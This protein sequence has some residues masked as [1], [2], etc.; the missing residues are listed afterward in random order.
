VADLLSDVFK[1]LGRVAWLLLGGDRHGNLLERFGSSCFGA[2]G[3]K[4][5]ST[6]ARS[7]RWQKKLSMNFDEFGYGL[8]SAIHAP[9]LSDIS[10]LTGMAIAVLSR[11]FTITI[12][13]LKEIDS[14]VHDY[15]TIANASK[16]TSRFSAC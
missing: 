6:V 2:A 16:R 10:P 4:A 3:C 13:F 5:L 1:L 12:N 15:R 8:P 14:D 11:R 7:V 9:R